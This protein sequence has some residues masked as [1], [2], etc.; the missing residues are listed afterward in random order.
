MKHFNGKKLVSLGFIAAMALLATSCISIPHKINFDDTVPKEETTVVLFAEGI[1]VLALN[2]VDVDEA[3]YGSSYWSNESANVTL[4]AGETDVEYDL[5]YV[6][7]NG[8]S[9]TTFSAKDLRLIYVFEAGKKYIVSFG[10]KGGFLGI[11]AKWGIFLTE[12]K[13]EIEFWEMHFN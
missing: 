3:W 10:S 4:P 7:S 8:Q 1:H 13:K 9:S 6:Q 11:G 5:Y 12:D 2:G